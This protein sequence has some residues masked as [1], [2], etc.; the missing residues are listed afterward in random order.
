MEQGGAKLLQHIVSALDDQLGSSRHLLRSDVRMDLE[1]FVASANLDERAVKAL[2]GLDEEVQQEV[3]R[4]GHLANIDNP[5]KTLM[6]R[7][8]HAQEKIM[9]HKKR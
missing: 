8:Y 2:R 3:M 4:R 7:I 1:T 5:S 6:G 9:A